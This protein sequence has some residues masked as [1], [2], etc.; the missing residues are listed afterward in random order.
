MDPYSA[1]TILYLRAIQGHS[2]GKHIN[3]SLKDNV[4]LPRDFAEHIYHVGSSH[5][6]HSII[7]SGLIPGGKD[8]KKGRHAVFFTAVN[9]MYIDHCREKDFDVTKPRIAVYKHNWKA[10]QNT[11]YWCNLRVVQSKG[12]QFFQTRSSSTT[13]YLRCVSRRCWSGSHEKKC[14]AKRLGLLLHRTELY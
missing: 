6:T 9:P 5:D 4:L 2:E 1:D 8:V 11:M 3:L 7:Q 14:T 10:H 12:L 13:L